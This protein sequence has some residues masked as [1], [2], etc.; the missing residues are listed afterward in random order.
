MFFLLL[1]R[2]TATHLQILARLGRLMQL[3]DFLPTL[4]AAEDS[5]L[6]FQ[7]ICD[8]DHSLAG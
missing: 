1:A 6:A 3:P 4:R 7:I 2:D 5:D 8:A